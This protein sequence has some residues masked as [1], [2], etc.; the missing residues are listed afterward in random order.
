MFHQAINAATIP[1]APPARFREWLGV[2]TPLTVVVN[3]YPVA[4]M[5]KVSHTVRKSEEKATVDLR[6]SSQRMKVKMNQPCC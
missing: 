2:V 6:V 1:K 3:M 4:S 5:R